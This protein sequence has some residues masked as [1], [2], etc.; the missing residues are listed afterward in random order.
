MNNTNLN[1]IVRE[2]KS[3][4][5]FHLPWYLEAV[6]RELSRPNIYEYTRY[7]TLFMS[8]FPHFCNNIYC[9]RIYQMWNL[10][11]RLLFGKPLRWFFLK[12]ILFYFL[13]LW[14]CWWVLYVFY[15]F[16]MSDMLCLC[17]IIVNFPN[18]HWKNFIPSFFFN[19]IKILL[20]VFQTVVTE[21]YHVL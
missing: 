12:V 9:A 6:G 16:T 5:N 21:C 20:A 13:S 4:L 14:T 18:F 19:G 2:L 3:K 10:L 1:H 15:I 7:R 17:V 8:L 11:R